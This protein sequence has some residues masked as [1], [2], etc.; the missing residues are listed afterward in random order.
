MVSILP[1][2]A[3]A[4]GQ[5]VRGRPGAG[6]L[7]GL[8]TVAATLIALWLAMA[9]QL[10]TPRWAAWT[11]MSLALPTRGQVG[12]KGLWRVGGSILGVVA[13]V[14]GTALFAQ[15]SVLVGAFLAGWCGLNAYVG[16]RLPG[17]ASY[18]TALSSLT[19]ALVLIL[20]ATD[21]LSVFGTG[22]STL[23]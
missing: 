9:L 10:D 14:L 6:I 2:L 16:G 17:L 12:I 3:G 1:P 20:A 7:F 8:R 4:R 5:E 18:G 23:R 22:L 19:A 15:D 13:A 11:V 21:P